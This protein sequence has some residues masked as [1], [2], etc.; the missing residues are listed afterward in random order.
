MKLQIVPVMA[1]AGGVASVGG[2]VWGFSQPQ[3]KTMEE[4]AQSLMLN[5]VVFLAAGVSVA[6]LILWAKGITK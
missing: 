6:A 4:E 5:R 1:L 2:L 3:A